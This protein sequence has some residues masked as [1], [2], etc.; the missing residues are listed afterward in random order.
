MPGFRPPLV[1]E[2]GSVG[3]TMRQKPRSEQSCG[4]CA[5]F[6]RNRASL[7]LPHQGECRTGP[8]TVVGMMAQTPQGTVPMAQGFW[9]PT[10]SSK[11]CAQ[12]QDRNNHPLFPDHDGTVPLTE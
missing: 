12:W 8:P 5:A 3:D 7:Q 1:E 2:Q 11:W 10:V 4:N 9:P 6:L